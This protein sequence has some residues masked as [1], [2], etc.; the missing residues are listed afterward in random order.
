M[1]GRFCNQ[2]G[3]ELRDGVKFCRVCGQPQPSAERP[4]NT[5]DT[6]QT[7]MPGQVATGAQ[8]APVPQPVPAAP[9]VPAPASAGRG[10][11]IGLG[12]GAGVGILAIVAVVA[13]LVVGHGLLPSRPA[14]DLGGSATSTATNA[15]AGTRADQ[16]ATNSADANSEGVEGTTGAADD[17][18]RTVTEMYDA[19]LSTDRRITGLANT[20]SSGRPYKSTS[21]ERQFLRDCKAAH[22]AEQEYVDGI[23]SVS[24]A[25][26]YQSDLDRV[27]RMHQLL[28][29]RLTVFVDAESAAVDAGPGLVGECCRGRRVQGQ[30]GR[31]RREHL[32]ERVRE[33]EESRPTRPTVGPHLWQRGPGAHRASGLLSCGKV[34]ERGDESRV[35]HVARSSCRCLTGTGLD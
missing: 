17:S 34:R 8:S 11:W 14:S 3:S 33:P 5:S 29:S 15:A 1:T 25:Q 2:C 26:S 22:D 23:A 10:L 21:A 9:A 18:Y 7:P 12:I 28:L 27:T 24:V 4:G 35:V 16:A 6:P 20:S 13:F 30:P 32:Q 19:A 31:E